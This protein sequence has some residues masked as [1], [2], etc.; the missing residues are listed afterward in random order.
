MLP[1]GGNKTITMH[2]DSISISE[3]TDKIYLNGTL[4]KAKHFSHLPIDRIFGIKKLLREH[5]K[6][7][8]ETEIITYIVGNEIFD[9]VGKDSIE[10]IIKKD[11]K[12][13]TVQR[14]IKDSFSIMQRLMYFC[15][16]LYYISDGN[17]KT[18]IQEKLKLLEISYGEESDE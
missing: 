12:C 3:S 13:T 14:P 6:F 17:T 10:T 18:Q 11:K 8:I 7:E 5:A 9:E 15:P 2:T 1:H 16:D 4:D